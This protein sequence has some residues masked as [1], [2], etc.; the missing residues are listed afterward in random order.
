MIKENLEMPL[1]NH[2]NYT[3]IECLRKVIE[4]FAEFRTAISDQERF[5][6]ALDL[7]QSLFT[8]LN[9]SMTLE[10][11]Q[12]L[13]QQHLLKIKMYEADMSE[14]RAKLQIKGKIKITM[15]DIL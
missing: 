8:F 13:F 2:N 3:E 10:E 9:R 11:R 7:I 6:E 15:E 1:I 14:K 12:K 5:S 4:E